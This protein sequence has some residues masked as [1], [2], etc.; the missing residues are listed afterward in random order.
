VTEAAG[1]GP[2]KITA[3]PGIEDS[4]L[5]AP[6]WHSIL[7]LVLLFV[8]MT[9]IPGMKSFLHAMQRWELLLV[10]LAFAWGL[11]LFL[12]WGMTLKRQRLGDLLK[13]K[14]QEEDDLLGEV[15]LGLQMGFYVLVFSF[16]ISFVFRHFYKSPRFGPPRTIFELA[17]YLALGLTAGFGEELIFRGYLF[18]QTQFLTGNSS[19]AVVGQAALFGLA[20]GYDQ[21]VAGFVHKFI[22]GLL[23][24]YLAIQRKSLLSSMVA[25]AFLNC[26][27]TLLAFAVSSI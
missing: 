22:S 10:E 1:T 8:P 25:H 15:G 19:V 16:V 13:G 20:H 7:L 4:K 6:I 24:G 9:L 18:R 2:G 12:H 27:I 5:L 26:T 11:V 23:F 3:K 17:G 21:T 14:W